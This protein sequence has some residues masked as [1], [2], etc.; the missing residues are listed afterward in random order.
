MDV[1]LIKSTKDGE[2]TSMRYCK[3]CYRRKYCF[4]I[5]H[6]DNCPC[7]ICLVKGICSEMCDEFSN[8]SDVIN[9]I[10]LKSFPNSV[11]SA[12]RWLKEDNGKL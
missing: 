8:Y 3:G 6:K 9:A 11:K 5:K 4:Y 12:E 1:Y 7:A 10:I 2:G